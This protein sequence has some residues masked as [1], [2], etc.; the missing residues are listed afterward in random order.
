MARW[1]EVLASSPALPLSGWPPWAAFF[2]SLGLSA[3]FG[4]ETEPHLVGLSGASAQLPSC[5]AFPFS[6]SVNVEE[7]LGPHCALSAGWVCPHPYSKTPPME[8]GWCLWSSLTR[9]SWDS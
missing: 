6:C 8:R 9:L 1:C 7:R 5:E 4:M 2:T 3:L